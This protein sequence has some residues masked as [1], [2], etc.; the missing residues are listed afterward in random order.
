MAEAS[1][2]IQASPNPTL[3]MTSVV[4]W[5]S[6]GRALELLEPNIWTSS[7]TFAQASPKQ[8]PPHHGSRP[9]RKTPLMLAVCR[10]LQVA[11]QVPGTLLRDVQCLHG[12]WQEAAVVNE[13]QHPRLAQGSAFRSAT[14]CSDTSSFALHA[15]MAPRREL[16]RIA[17]RQ[18]TKV[19]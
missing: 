17:G 4:R 8:G 1:C 14:S 9:R 11:W 15:P 2:N 16:Q 19:K 13:T 3:S 10:D 7:K 12:D 5:R 18:A 6:D